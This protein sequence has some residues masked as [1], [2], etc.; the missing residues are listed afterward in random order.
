MTGMGSDG[1]L[2]LRLMKRAGAHIVAQDQET[3]TVF[4]MP[5]EAINAGI[6]DNILPLEEISGY[7]SKLIGSR[8]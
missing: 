2:G 4:G 6:V 3:S 1:T 5:R 8:S 7:L